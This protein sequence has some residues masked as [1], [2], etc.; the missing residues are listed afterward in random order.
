MS[1]MY[2]YYHAK[3]ANCSSERTHF[4]FDCYLC[5]TKSFFCKKCTHEYEDFQLTL[6]EMEKMHSKLNHLAV[7]IV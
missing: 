1:E 2:I 6:I 3:C 4:H 5:N 7:D